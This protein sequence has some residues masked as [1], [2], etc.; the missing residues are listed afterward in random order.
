M[1][2]RFITF[3]GGILALSLLVHPVFAQTSA[4]NSIYIYNQNGTWSG[5][6]LSEGRTL[7]SS[8]CQIYTY[9]HAIQWLSG[10]K[11]TSSNGGDLLQTLID[12]DN[13]PSDKYQGGGSAQKRYHSYIVNK[14]EIAE[15]TLIPS[16]EA[17]Y[18]AHFQNGGVVIANPGGHYVVAVGYTYRD[19]TNEGN[20]EMLIQVVDSS[21]G[22]TIKRRADGSIYSF[23]TFK[24]IPQSSYKSYSQGGQYWVAYEEFI[25]FRR[26]R[27]YLPK[28]SVEDPVMPENDTHTNPLYFGIPIIIVLFLFFVFIVSYKKRKTDYRSKQ[29]S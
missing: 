17:E 1:K 29:I 27:A 22:S 2:N 12:I 10:D 5:K 8:G 7:R 18:E 16:T 15:P 14:L 9:A 21:M 4:R 24:V 3:L 20:P 19:V 6:A 25:A 28:L 26:D 23:S 11:K 13:D